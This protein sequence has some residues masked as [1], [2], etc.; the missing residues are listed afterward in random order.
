MYSTRWL[1]KEQSSE[2]NGPNL[3]SRG[4]RGKGSSNHGVHWCTYHL[5]SHETSV[6][7]EVNFLKR[8]H[9]PIHHQS[10]IPIAEQPHLHFIGE[11]LHLQSGN[12]HQVKQHMHLRTCRQDRPEIRSLRFNYV[13]MWSHLNLSVEYTHRL[14]NML[15][16]GSVLQFLQQFQ[17]VK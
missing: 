12:A 10:I 3:G 16:H 7:Y 14:Q 1:E 8:D 13:F 11:T 5:D 4:L 15:Q 2:S 6:S 9:H 17:D